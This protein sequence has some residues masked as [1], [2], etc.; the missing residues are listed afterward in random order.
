MLTEVSL[1]RKRYT[2]STGERRI[3]VHTAAAPVVADLGEMYR[4]ADTGAIVSV[5]SRLGRI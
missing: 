3:R 4:Q 5:F 1:A 2:S